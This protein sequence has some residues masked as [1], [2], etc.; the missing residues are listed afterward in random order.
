MYVKTVKSN[1]FDWYIVGYVPMSDMMQGL[2]M[3][4]IFT[5]AD[6]C[7]HRPGGLILRSIGPK[8]TNPFERIIKG[9]AEIEKENYTV[10]INDSSFYETQYICTQFNHMSSHLHQLIHD[11]YLSQLREKEA[12]FV[13]LQAQINPH[14][15][16]NALD[17]MNMML[18]VRGQGGY[19]RFRDA[20]KRIDAIQYRYYAEPGN[21]LGGS[22]TGQE[23]SVYPENP[24]WR[25]VVLF[26][27]LPGRNQE[28]SDCQA[29]D[30]AIGG[31]RYYPWN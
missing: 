22:G 30:P 14:F 11:V 27:C 17:N 23:I 12:Q 4:L 1:Y 24:F 5:R 3:R 10:Q 28:Y 16:Y 15:L 2:N 20:V 26:D 13:A 25:A 31:K 21:P 7:G 18:I 9:M 6:Y 19:Q 8:I 29:A